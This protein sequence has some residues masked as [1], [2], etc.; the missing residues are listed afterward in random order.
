MSKNIFPKN[1]LLQM[2]NIFGSYVAVF[3]CVFVFAFRYGKIPK[4]T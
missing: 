2:T 3:L 1:G 4:L